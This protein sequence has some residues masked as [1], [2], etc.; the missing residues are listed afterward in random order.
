MEMDYSLQEVDLTTSAKPIRSILHSFLATKVYR[1]KQ[2]RKS[3]RQLSSS[4]TL[5]KDVGTNM[6]RNGLPHKVQPALNAVVE[7]LQASEMEHSQD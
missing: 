5:T 4:N 3:A 2:Q 1:P 7:K 6:K